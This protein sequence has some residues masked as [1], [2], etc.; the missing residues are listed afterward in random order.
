MSSKPDQN[1]A[2]LRADTTIEHCDRCDADTIHQ[3]RLNVR[4]KHGEQEG[5]GKQ[6][7]RTATCQDCGEQETVRLGV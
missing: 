7:Y 6:P 4:S 1:D 2:K 3:I 5:R